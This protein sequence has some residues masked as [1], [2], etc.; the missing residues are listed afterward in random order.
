MKLNVNR[1][2]KKRISERAKLNTLKRLFGILILLV[3][4]YYCTG[5]TLKSVDSTRHIHVN[6]IIPRLGLGMSRHVISEFGIAYMRSNFTDHK[7]L[8]L[9]TNNT[10]YYLSVETM[11]PYRTPIVYGYKLGV[12]TIHIGHVTSAAG[13]EFGEYHKDSVSSFVLTPR[14]GIPLINGTLAY[15][16]RLFFNPDMR[17]EIGR[18]SISLTYCFNRRSN[19]A[20]HS[21]LD[22]YKNK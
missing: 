22:K 4:N 6:N 21:L 5:Q 7:N 8:G 13:I 9:N 19:K 16:I 1:N 3:S 18:H 15:G 17:R 12:E 10:I 20:F 11:T 14:I 2:S